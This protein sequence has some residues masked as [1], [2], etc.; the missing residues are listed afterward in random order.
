MPLLLVYVEKSVTNMFS[1]LMTY[2]RNGA[3]G[4]RRLPK[5]LIDSYAL[6]KHK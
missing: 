4:A 2:S 6:K 3:V 1:K 5:L